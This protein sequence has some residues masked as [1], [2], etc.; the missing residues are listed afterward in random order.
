MTPSETAI[1]LAMAAAFDSRTVGETDVMAWHAVLEDLPLE[2][3]EAAVLAWYREHR[4]RLMPS[5]VRHAVKAIR[6][7][8]IERDGGTE[9]PDA[10]PD[11]VVAY[12]A[13][14]REG[15][16]RAADGTERPRPVAQ[17]IAGATP[18]LTETGP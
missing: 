10:D 3:C 1:L 6:R 12:L 4:E 15:R 16:R 9:P 17:L 14:F 7:D 13:A 18:Q 2:D 8:R 11:D 5:D